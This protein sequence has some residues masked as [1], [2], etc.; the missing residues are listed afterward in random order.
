MEFH[1]GDTVMHWSHGLGQV[2]AKEER[3][4]VGQNRLYYMVKIQDI[5]IWVPVD[6]MLAGRLRPPT[7]ASAFQKLF[8]ILSGPAQT[9]PVD[10]RERKTNLHTR[11][12]AGNAESLCHV[13]RDLSALVRERA[14]N[15][16]DKMTLRHARSMLLGEW[17]YSLKIP[18]AQAEDS[19]GQLLEVPSAG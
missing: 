17:G 15:E 3:Q 13:I 8:A 9:L 2:M 10:R 19:L 7:A 14:L 11:M 1:V 18:P 12:A 5:N 16:D 4:V 6:E